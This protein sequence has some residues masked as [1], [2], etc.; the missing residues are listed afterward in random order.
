MTANLGSMLMQKVG[1]AIP[2]LPVSLISTILLDG[3]QQ[4]MIQVEIQE[5]ARQE[6]DRLLAKGAHIHIPRKNR[7]Y[8]VEVGLRMLILR[9]ALVLEGGKYHYKPKQEELI[10]YYA[11]AI[12][13]LR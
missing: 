4:P 3:P 2:I 6:L 10:R 7:D 1:E 12:V 8:A 11:N 13:H 5:L 9:R